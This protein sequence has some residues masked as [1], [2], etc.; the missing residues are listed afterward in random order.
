MQL[1]YNARPHLYL[2]ADITVGDNVFLSRETK[3][4]IIFRDIVQERCSDAN[5][6]DNMSFVFVYKYVFNTVCLIY[7]W[8][9]TVNSATGNR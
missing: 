6:N 2:S 4:V 1:S 8:R 3:K 9:P 7:Q 5:T